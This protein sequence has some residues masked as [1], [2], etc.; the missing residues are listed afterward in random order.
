MSL[1]SG[2]FNLTIR[3]AHEGDVPAVFFMLHE[4]AIAQ[5]GEDELCANPFNLREDGFGREP[6]FR[7]L[8]AEVDG[9]PVGLILYFVVYSTWSSRNG[10]CIEDLYVTPQSRRQG[11]GRALM[12]EVARNAIETGC[13]YIQWAALRA[14]NSA[15]RF[16]E[17][18]GARTLSEWMLLRVHGEELNRL[19]KAPTNFRPNRN[20]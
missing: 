5:G 6:R 9:K 11:I 2:D 3:M 1:K 16:Y 14:N 15:L 18:I 20:E 10:L 7:C 13:R 17:S 4:S 12:S 19:S 8:L